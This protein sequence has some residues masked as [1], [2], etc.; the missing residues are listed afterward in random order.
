MIKE[1]VKRDGRTVPFDEC[2]IRTAVQKAMKEVNYPHLGMADCVV[3]P[4]RDLEKETMSVEEIQ[5]E[6][7]K[8]LIQC[9]LVDVAKAYIRYRYKRE[10]VRQGNTTDITIKELLDGTN[11]YWNTEN[12]NKNAKIVTVQRDY[13]AGITSTD[14][15]KR[16]LLPKEVVEAHEKG[17]IHQH[18]MDYMAQ[19]SLNNCFSGS[20]K[21]VTDQGVKRF[22]EFYDGDKV[23]VKD[24]DGVWRDATVRTYGK[25]KM[26]DITF[27]ACRQTKT[28]TCTQNHRWILK[29]GTV[30]TELKEGDI[31][32]ALP[33]SRTNISQMNDEECKYFA[34]GFILGD[35]SDITNSTGV[36]CR[37][38]GDKVSYL[39]I[40]TR[41]GYQYNQIKGS[42]DYIVYSKKEYSKQT[43]LNNQCWKL[44][45]LK[46]KIALFNGYYAADGGMRANKVSTSDKRLEEMIEDI[47]A[48][49]GY[50]IS[51]AKDEVRDTPYKS[52]AYL[53]TYQ[54]TVHQP[55]NHQ[56]K[57]EEI[58]PHHSK[59]YPNS[60]GRKGTRIVNPPMVAWCVEEP[61]THSFTLDGGIVTG[62]CGLINLEDM[63]M[64]GTVVNGVAI[65]AQHRLLTATTVATQIIAAVASSQYGGCTIT[66][67]HLAPFV[68]MSYNAYLDEG[69]GLFNFIG[70]QVEREERIKNYADQKIKKEI[71][72]SVQTFN[73]QV[74][75]M[76]TTNGQAP[77][78]SVFMWIDENPEYEKEVVALIEEFLRQRI[79]GMKNEVGVYITQAFPKLLYCLDDNNITP[80]S[81]YYWLTQLAAKSTA[82]RMNPDYISAKIMREQ[83]IDQ[84]GDGNVYPCMGC[85]SFLTPDRIKGNPA[86]ALNYVEGKPKYYGRFN[87]G[88]TTINLPDVALSSDGDFNK[89]WELLEERCELCH[90]GLQARIER[91]DQCTSD[92]APILWQH[93]AYARLG[94]GEPIAPLIRG[95]Y[96]TASL[97]YAGL[98]ECVK[99]MTGYS[100]SHKP[101]GYDF[102]IQVMQKLN[103]FCS[104][105]KK[106]EDIDYSVYG[107]PIESTTYKFASGLKERFGVIEGITDKNYIT[108]SYHICVTEHI[109]AFEKLALESDFQRLSPGGQISYVESANL[110]NNIPAVMSLIQFIYDNNLYAELNTKSDYCQVCGYDGEMVIDDNMEWKCPNCGNKDHDKLNIARRTCGYIG[111]NFWNFGRTQEIKERY[112]HLGGDE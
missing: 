86:H 44:L 99:Y 79:K 34:F 32:T 27:R 50:Y 54:F 17:I 22:D 30:T 88:V 100:H 42:D 87:V 59:R 95:G 104:K 19:R 109:N 78:L 84:Y 105:W 3:Y 46:Q 101:E 9:K 36:R 64:N 15:A 94:K 13:L 14:I 6:V 65:D 8:L 10:L 82:K 37:L 21:F 38:C 89:F 103:D 43:F 57:V 16:F 33:D 71:K 4:I 35:G 2:K 52:D 98:Y 90:K 68:R 70:D 92:V 62:N 53:K 18:D 11:E 102:A 110:T 111:N 75:S 85:R 29:D 67:S 106:E 80:D 74:N 97:G 39:D 28:I 12:S 58:K 77:F 41:S 24:K 31:L 72:D 96:A 45:S 26:F 5:D 7:E 61:V 83:K 48:L 81:K 55:V 93:G 51:S 91:L 20:T 112:V 66:L 25:Q 23:K 47:S 40:F 108:N 73:Y 60:H 49:A 107:T 56:W 1:V 63:L 76:A 69:K